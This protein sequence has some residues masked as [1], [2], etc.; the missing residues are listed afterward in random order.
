MSE[1]VKLNH[2]FERFGELRGSQPVKKTSESVSESFKKKLGEMSGSDE[3]KPAPSRSRARRHQP[4][5][6]AKLEK[7]LPEEQKNQPTMPKFVK[8]R[9]ISMKHAKRLARYAPLIENAAK[10]HNVP[11]ELICGVIL[12]ESGAN[13]RARSHCGARGLMQLMPATARRFGVRNSY[14]PAQ[15]IDGGVKYLRWL[16]DRFD[17]DIELAL[18]G[19]NAGEGNV[20]KYGNKIPPFRETQ[21]Y[22]PA[23]LSFT[24]SIVDIFSEKLAVNLPAYARKA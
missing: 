1:N 24:Q 13:P 3:S 21:A 14:D 4:P 17:G 19:Y 8:S 9:R 2:L 6:I 7:E 11:V 5:K 16:L 23:V 18:A 10:K 12:Q 20:E 15:N 22:V